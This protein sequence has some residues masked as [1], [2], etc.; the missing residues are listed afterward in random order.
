M[1]SQ[2]SVATA[3]SSPTWPVDMPGARGRIARRSWTSSR[4][5]ARASWR[6]RTTALVRAVLRSA[7]PIHHGD[8][9]V[10]RRVPGLAAV[11]EGR[12][13]LALGAVRVASES[14]VRLRVVEAERRQD[15]RLEHRR[16]PDR[17]VDR[18]RIQSR[19]ARAA[20]D[21]WLSN[22]GPGGRTRRSSATSGRASTAPAV[23][24]RA[25]EG[26]VPVVDAVLARGVPGLAVVAVP[27]VT[28]GVV[29]P[30][31]GRPSP[32]RRPGWR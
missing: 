18:A 32:G 8:V 16:R 21:R 12:E 29:G 25:D 9:H 26:P 28:V 23:R 15:A 6:R 30:A 3:M 17:R 31:G 24:V 10:V 14:L 27:T 22:G 19:V 4:R 13:F 1:L 11:V 7:A 20:A 5:R 2:L